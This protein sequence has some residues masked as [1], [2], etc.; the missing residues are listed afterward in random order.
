MSESPQSILK[1]VFGYDEFRP[2]QKEIIANVL[3]RRDTLVI[4][5]TGGGKSLCYQIPALL[6]DGLTIVV[7]PLISLMKDQV[8]Q[9]K[10][11]GVAAEFLNSSLLP[12]EYERI[13]QDVRAHRIKLL[14]VAPEGL[15]TPRMFNLLQSQQ[16]D[17]LTIDEAHCISEWGHDFRPEYRR[18]VDVRAQFPAAVCI[19]LTA[20]ATPRVQQDI[21]QSLHFDQ[22]NEFIGSFNREN[23][24]LQVVPK[25]DPSRQV[26]HF[27]EQHAE[28][29]GI[30]YCFSRR[31]V[32]ELAAFLAAYN[33]SVLP[34]HAGLADEERKK[35]QELFIRDDVQIIVATIAFG[36]GINKPNVRFVIH[37]DLPKNIESYYQE[38]GRAGRD[39]LRAD[40]LLLFS[41]AD[42]QKIR[43]FIDQKQDAHERR[44]ALDHLEALIRYAESDACRRAP[45]LTYFGENY[46]QQ[47]CGMCDN[48]LAEKEQHVDISVAA[49][50]F[51]SCVKRTKELFG[52]MHIIDVLRGSESKKVMDFGHQHIS[53]Y[54]IGKEFS[55]QQ[56]LQLAHQFIS[57]DLL[58]KEVDYGSLKITEKGA[59]VLF[60][61][62]KVYGRLEEYVETRTTGIEYDTR[63]FD[64]LRARRK[65]IAD[66]QNV[67]PYVIFSDRSLIEMATFF[68]QSRDQFLDISGVGIS[69]LN[70]YGHLFL[71]IIRNFCEEHNIAERPKKP[72]LSL[73]THQAS[74][75]K[76]F[77]QVGEAFCAGRSIAELAREY[78]VKMQTITRH[79]Y[80]Y[81]KA[82]NPIPFKQLLEGIDISAEQQQT[83]LAAFE[84]LGVDYLAPVFEAL[85]GGVSYDALHV[86]RLYCLAAKNSRAETM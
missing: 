72:Q 34:Y 25:N 47:T 5:P 50:K 46:T 11:V 35:N 15:L 31:Q 1:S 44:N 39:G 2:L 60:R 18:L 16:V 37:Y 10:E 65:Q 54:G 19:A 81:V 56:W 24:F 29:S 83:V 86:M 64:I 57:Q 32:N 43:Y 27:L 85:N 73:P 75:K 40:C 76:R 71:K 78:N 80:D 9:L 63:L 14:Y 68:P 6:F 61:G 74:G 8:E 13:V 21:M 84:R 48:C 52:A 23:L 41:Y 4:M 36:M 30:I 12:E 67:P 58:F 17:C 55:K 26:V 3:A 79:L 70:R 33:Y 59:D 38:I 20:T 53:T 7:S 42:Q 45:I 49:Q 82:G 77:Q 51:L 69:K 62:K 22:S 66:R 28:Q